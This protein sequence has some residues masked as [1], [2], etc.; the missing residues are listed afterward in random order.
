M[1]VDG[2]TTTCGQRYAYS[3]TKANEW[4]GW[5]LILTALSSIRKVATS[6]EAAEAATAAVVVIVPAA[7]AAAEYPAGANHYKSYSWGIECVTASVF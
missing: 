5:V 2:R 7:A 6:V 1:V 3:H 4:N